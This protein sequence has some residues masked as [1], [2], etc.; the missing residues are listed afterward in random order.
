MNCLFRKIFVLVIVSAASFG[1]S[2]NSPADEASRPTTFCN[3]LNLDYRFQLNTPSRR[4]AADP[5]LL[6]YKG[7]YWLFPSKSGGYWHS[8][9]LAN[10]TFIH[11]TGL[12]L[13]D[14]APTVEIIG[15]RMYFTAAGSKA[16][17][18]TDDPE[19]GVWNKVGELKDYGDPDFFADDDGRVYIYFGCHPNGP[20]QVAELDPAHQFKVIKGPV[21]C[22]SGDCA[23]HGWEVKGDD[24]R[25]YPKG[26]TNMPYIEGSWMTKH[27]GI[28][29]LQYSAPGTEFKTYG[30]GVYTSTN[31]MGPF[32]YAPYSPF[33]FK[34]TGFICGAG[35]SSTMED[36]QGRYWHISTMTISI[37]HMFERRLGFF[38]AGFTPDGQMFCNTYLGDYPQFVPA[39][40]KNPEDNSP[41]WMLLSYRK[42]ATASSE[43]KGFPVENA[44]DENVRHWWSAAMDE[45]GEWLQVDLGKPCRIDALQINF[46]DQG[47]T[48]LGR[49][50]ND[51][52]RYHVQISDDAAHWQT[53]LDRDNNTLDLPHDYTQLE[54][55]VTARYVRLVNVHMP[56]GALFSVS[57]FRIFGSGLGKAPA[58][59]KDV[60]AVRDDSNLRH[61]HVSW[62][63][64][65]NADFYIIRYGISRDRL[66]GN[67]QVYGT[68]EFDINSLNLGVSYYLTVDAINDNGITK[69]TKIL[70]V[71]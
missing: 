11:P 65:K 59:V 68:N 7:E 71:K 3:P 34:P 26:G 36:Y 14:Y 6:R 13:E 31:P 2:I 30:D 53:C 27:N 41:G 15:G 50:D 46:A 64:V 21:A 18:A 38:P 63:P 52:Y 20:I 70:A 49:V 66:F 37:R 12:P 69:G 25:S 61:A 33:S 17:F 56:A 10:W 23:Q 57:G 45:P 55:P 22:F 51:A 24:N 48:T 58:K 1:W 40:I 44:F 29:Y 54:Q 5:T 60:K 42:P 16:V 47:A 67:Y 35:H 62:R 43:L 19:K 39:S 28:Y 32:T 8:R 9:D 4:E